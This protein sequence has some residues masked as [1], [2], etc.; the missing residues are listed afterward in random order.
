MNL[1]HKLCPHFIKI[2]NSQIH[3]EMLSTFSAW[4]SFRL[5]ISIFFINVLKWHVQTHLIT[6]L[7][8]LF[9]LLFTEQ[10]INI[11]ETE[12]NLHD[13][14]ASTASHH[15]TA[16]SQQDENKFI[17]WTTKK[18]PIWYY[19]N[20]ISGCF[21]PRILKLHEVLPEKVRKNQ[22]FAKAIFFNEL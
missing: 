3:Y 5:N 4:S 16:L 7:V 17:H 14:S 18:Y 12:T 19:N 9:L 22:V 8:E 10:I 6:V 20:F 13:H 1:Y 21:T 2:K 11:K 15:N